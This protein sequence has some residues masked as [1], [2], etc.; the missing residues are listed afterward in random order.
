M[1]V[2]YKIF[3]NRLEKDYLIS[4]FCGIGLSCYVIWMLGVKFWL[5]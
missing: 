2:I 1:E 3:K 5:K 4:F